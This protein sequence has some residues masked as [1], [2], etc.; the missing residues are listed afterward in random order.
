MLNFFYFL[1]T[2]LDIWLY[3]TSGYYLKDN[4]QTKYMNQILG[5]YLYVY[6]NYQQNNWS[7]LL[8]LVE[9]A[10]NSVPSTTTDIFPFFANKEYHPNIIV[11]PEY[12]I[13]SS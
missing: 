6:H 11:H 13:A 8:L 5:Q 7:E 9:F 12:N 4:G 2:A 1:G 3:F 10:Y